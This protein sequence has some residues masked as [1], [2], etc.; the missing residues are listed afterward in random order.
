MNEIIGASVGAVLGAALGG[1][2]TYMVTVRAARVSS[3]RA[4]T[5]R[6]YEDWHSV[7]MLDARIGAADV[8]KRFGEDTF[9]EMYLNLESVDRRSDWVKVSRVVH[10]FELLGT[11]LREGQLDDAMFWR[12][13]SRYVAYWRSEML[14]GLMR[15]SEE[16]DGP[17]EHGWTQAVRFLQP[18]ETPN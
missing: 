17:L 18:P 10:F 9:S 12:L 2:I 7:E 13:F 11:L 1:F 15:R 4:L 14:D 5:L 16:R 3:N 6:L 8:L